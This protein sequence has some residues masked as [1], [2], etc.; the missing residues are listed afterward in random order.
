MQHSTGYIVG[1]A[2][3]VCLVCAIFVASSAVGLKPLQDANKL[4]DRQ[5]KVL[6][7]AGLLE[8]GASIPRD[9]IT[10]L[11][12]TTIK[13]K[14]IDLKT[15]AAN[16]EV[17]V[18]DFDQQAA[19]SDPARSFEAPSNAAKVRRLPNNALVFDVV[20]K[21]KLKALILPI[22]GYG[23]WG[24]LYGYIAL[25]P[26]ARTI[27]GITFYKHKETPGLGGEVDNPRWKAGWPGRLAFD[28]RGNTKI[29]VKKGVAGSPEDDPYNVDGL[30]GATITSRGVTSLVRFWLGDDGFGP[31][32]AS[33]RTQAGI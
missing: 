32:L 22:E 21:G 5:T 1:F 16:A 24:T 9:E 26:D 6:T 30:S 10:S 31:Y 20:E 2:V 33:Y 11:F 15:G 7:V 27:V 18:A 23:L 8:E 29:A 3:S 14:V 28:D 19:A 17:N 25:A 4:L 12:E 13:Q